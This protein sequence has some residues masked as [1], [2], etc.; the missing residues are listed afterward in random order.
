MRPKPFLLI[1]VLACLAVA[2]TTALAQYG[3]P[4]KGSWSGD[5]GTSKENRNRVL[6]DLNWD[7]KAVTGTINP[8]SDAVP[9]T[10]ATLDPT[11]WTVHFE[12]DGKDLKGRTVRYV[13]DGKLQNLGSYYRVIGG[14]WSQGAL[15]GDFKITRN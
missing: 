4:L 6:L 11:T 1:S 3:H 2:T 9:L 10:T 12:A 5:W 7:G 15:R 8:G 14:T 13:I